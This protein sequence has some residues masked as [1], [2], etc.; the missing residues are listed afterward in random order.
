MEGNN[1]K[2]AGINPTNPAN[3][4]KPTSSSPV[5]EQESKTF[6]QE[7]KEEDGLDR[8]YEEKKKV[9]IALISDIDI[10]SVYRKVNSEHIPDRHDNIGSSI[11]SVRKLMASSGEMEKY[12][13]TLLGIAANHPDFVMR[14]SKWFNNIAV[15]VGS[16]G[17]EFDCSFNWRKKSDYIEYKRLESIIEDEYDNTDK[18]TPKLLKDAIKK[19]IDALHDLEATR[20]LYGM[21]VN[22][23]DYLIYRHCLLYPDV[24][25]DIQL[26]HFDNRV[27]FYIKDENKEAARAKKRQQYANQAKRNYLEI[28]DDKNKF[29]DIFVCY[30]AALN[31]N[32]LS[33][34]NQESAIKERMLDEYASKEPEKFNKLFNNRNIHL[35]ALIEEAIAKG[36][37]LR[38]SVNHNIMTPEGNFIGG[39]MKEAIAYLLNP[40]NADFKKTLEIKIKY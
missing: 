24:A 36:E 7:Y 28:I 25:K 26:V 8:P 17:Y 4:I 39:N 38:S 13:P 23:S 34:L 35:Q 20:Y 2:P 10:A 37:L 40:D 9:V 30:C 33:N 6:A 27:R 3:P 15:F 31:L 12:M 18:S 21:P 29:K 32:I 22:V 14:V 16:D 5:K 1:I 19:R 11:M